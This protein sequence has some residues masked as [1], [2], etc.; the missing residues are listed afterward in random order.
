MSVSIEF[1]DFDELATLLN[2]DISRLPDVV[3]KVEWDAINNVPMSLS[4]MRNTLQTLDD[5]TFDNTDDMIDVAI[6]QNM[7]TD[8]EAN[9]S[10]FDVDQWVQTHT[11]ELLAVYEARHGLVYGMTDDLYLWYMDQ[12]NRNS[13]LNY[14]LF[15]C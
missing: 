4:E 12:Q 10:G 7:L 6:S 11:D 2:V 5:I 15:F 9:A 8:D 3:L 13:T 1:E 14:V